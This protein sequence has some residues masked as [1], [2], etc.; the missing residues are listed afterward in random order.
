MLVTADSLPCQCFFVLS[1]SM[2]C[3]G[4]LN[5]RLCWGIS[6]LL[7]LDT[8]TPLPFR[9]LCAGR[10]WSSLVWGII[11]CSKAVTVMRRLLSMQ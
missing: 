4:F 5:N 3:L 9:Q 11:V 10:D 7:Q 8:L 1:A 2:H 6:S